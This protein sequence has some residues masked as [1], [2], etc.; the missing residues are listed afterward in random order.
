MA[1]Y[2]IGAVPR[3]LR[4]GGYL[5]GHEV[6]LS[7]LMETRLSKKGHVG[8]KKKELRKISDE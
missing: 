8:P 7:D 2:W 5:S 1:G 4:R 6:L 3:V